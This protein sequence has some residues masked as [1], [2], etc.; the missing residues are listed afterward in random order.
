M[1]VT[2]NFAVNGQVVMLVAISSYCSFS[3]FSLSFA[4]YVSVS[5]FPYIR[6]TF[7][8]EHEEVDK[9]FFGHKLFLL[10]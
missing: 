10:P 3:L 7:V 4:L 2:V 9:G 1:G 6:S 8:A 5:H